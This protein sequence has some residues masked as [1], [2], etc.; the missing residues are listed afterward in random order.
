MP[1]SKL[2]MSVSADDDASSLNG[3]ITEEHPTSSFPTPPTRKKCL[4]AWP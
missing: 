3:S 4:F 2:Y 1:K